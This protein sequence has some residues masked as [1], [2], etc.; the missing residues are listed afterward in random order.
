M[1]PLEF[2]AANA[3][4]LFLGA[5]C[6]GTL[7]MVASLSA[8]Q[9]KASAT[10]GAGLM[11]GTALAVI[12]P[13]GAEAFYEARESLVAA[14]KHAPPSAC[15]G[16]ALTAGFVLMLVVENLGGGAGC[17]GGGGVRH[18]Q[19]KHGGYESDDAE[20]GLA[21]GAACASAAC[22]PGRGGGGG[23]AG[24]GPG[25]A[26]ALGST[27]KAK[28]RKGTAAAATASIWEM[29][30]V[31][32]LVG[33]LVHSAADGAAVGVAACAPDRSLE[34]LV[35][36]AIMMHK[37]PAA[38][39]LCTYLLRCGWGAAMTRRAMLTFS[40][41]SPAAA[42]ATYVLMTQVPFLHNPMAVP[43]CLLLS[44]GTFLY[45]A[46]I[47]I[48][49]EMLGT[50]GHFTRSQVM[51]VILGALIPLVLSLGHAH[52]HGGHGHD[53]NGDDGHG[54]AASLAHAHADADA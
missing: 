9:L 5:Y 27:S 4:V 32:T 36:A 30:G 22:S 34:V 37:A 21:A 43:M 26:P 38:F 47:H 49:P 12:V 25:D 53:H 52:D 1:G 48:L 13:E 50:S 23:G 6:A 41:A 31:H 17:A 11:V 7:P 42:I 10:L 2:L 51:W 19:H 44:G 35:C 24:G 15:V 45:A 39:G 3:V 20:G 8:E 16:A 54:H 28:A 46:C 40:A 18:L 14:R 29:E 33:I